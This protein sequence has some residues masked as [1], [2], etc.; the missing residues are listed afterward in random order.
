MEN[1]SSSYSLRSMMGQEEKNVILSL[2]FKNKMTK[3]VAFHHTY[4]ILCVCD[5]VSMAKTKVQGLWLIYACSN[6]SKGIAISASSAI[7]FERDGVYLLDNFDVTGLEC[8]LTSVGQVDAPKYKISREAKMDV[9]AKA[10]YQLYTPEKEVRNRPRPTSRQAQMDRRVVNKKVDTRDKKT[11]RRVER[12]TVDTTQTLRK[13][14]KELSALVQQLSSDRVVDRPKKDRRQQ[15][16][17]VKKEPRNL[18]DTRM[19]EQTADC[20]SQDEDIGS[21]LD[22]LENAVKSWPAVQKEEDEQVYQKE[23]EKLTE[24]DS[25]VKP[26]HYDVHHDDVDVSKKDDRLSPEPSSPVQ[27]VTSKPWEESDED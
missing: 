27:V 6:V 17:E 26:A 25:W 9:L 21:E 13:E 2:T 14:L 5:S 16:I 19:Q 3:A 23:K 7:M 11:S 12:D 24:R 4:G 15:R 8:K 18:I 20:H 1:V 22:K 10:K